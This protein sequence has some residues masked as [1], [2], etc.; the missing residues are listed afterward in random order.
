[1]NRRPE[2]QHEY[3]LLHTYCQLKEGQ[4]Q[5]RTQRVEDLAAMESES[6]K[7]ACVLYHQPPDYNREELTVNTDHRLGPGL[8]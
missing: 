1:M 7:G 6:V 4:A 5:Q 3:I 2:G 8:T